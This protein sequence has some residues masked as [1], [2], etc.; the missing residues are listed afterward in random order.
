MVRHLARC[1]IAGLFGTAGRGGAFRTNGKR[2]D[3]QTVMERTAS[4]LRQA[5]LGSR[6]F[7][8]VGQPCIDAV[9]LIREGVTE[10]GSPRGM[11]PSGSSRRTISSWRARRGGNWR[12]STKGAPRS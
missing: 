11:R 7:G 1:L 4:F 12:S 5:L 6:A 10:N 3:A 8:A 9:A 2:V